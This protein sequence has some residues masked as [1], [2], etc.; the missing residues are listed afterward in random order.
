METFNI[1]TAG[2]FV[3]GVFMVTRIVALAVWHF[4]RT[5]QKWEAP[6]PLPAEIP[7]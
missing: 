1:N 3:V 6:G 7:E 5:E 2:L 4:G